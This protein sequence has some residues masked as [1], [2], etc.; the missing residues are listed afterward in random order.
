VLLASIPWLH[1]EAAEWQQVAID[2]E[3]NRGTGR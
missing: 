2:G 3:D 1:V